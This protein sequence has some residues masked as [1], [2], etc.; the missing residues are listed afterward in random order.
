MS[1]PGGRPDRPTVGVVVMAYG[2]PG[3]P[4]DVESYYTHIRRGRP[5]S[6]EQLATLR[7]RYEA[8]GGTSALAARTAAQI[9]VLDAALEA[10][11]PGRFAVTL[12]QKH[13]SPFIEDGVAALARTGVDHVVGVVLAPHFS[14]ASV[15]E[16]QA[17][18][19][20]AAAEAGVGFSA[21]ERWHD[22]PSY[23]AFLAGA[24]RDALVELPASTEVVFTAC[25]L[26]P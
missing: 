21:I 23:R 25:I 2:T 18:A 19:A 8:L 13:A 15:G 11:A 5:P 14:R 22:L 3:S 1:D 9:A 24:V 6:E 10:R 17:R 4:D 12:G 20:E 7:A 16:Y 26:L